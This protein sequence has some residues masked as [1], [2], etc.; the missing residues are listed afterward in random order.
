MGDS[1]DFEMVF[2]P[3]VKV[4]HMGK[5]QSN[6]TPFTKKKRHYRSLAQIDIF[7]GSVKDQSFS[8]SSRKIQRHVLLPGEEQRYDSML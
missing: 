7:N 1:Q 5:F 3:L 2:P 4:K 8:L 6:S